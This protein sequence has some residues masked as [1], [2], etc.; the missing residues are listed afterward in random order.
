[1]NFTKSK[2]ARPETTRTAMMRRAKA[3]QLASIDGITVSL[4]AKHHVVSRWV[5]AN[6]QKKRSFPTPIHVVGNKRQIRYYNVTD[7]DNYFEHV[8]FFHKKKGDALAAKLLHAF[9]TEIR[10]P[11]KKATKCVMESAPMRKKGILYV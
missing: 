7:L 11:F 10:P 2:F 9:I 4:Y 1:M 8:A 3:K 6:H 5:A